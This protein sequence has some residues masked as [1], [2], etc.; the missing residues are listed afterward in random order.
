[1]FESE[2]GCPEATPP[3]F[4]QRI[5]DQYHTI[6]VRELTGSGS[7]IWDGLLP[8]IR[9]E[10]VKTVSQER[11]FQ[12]VVTSPPEQL[13]PGAVVLTGGVVGAQKLGRLDY[14]QVTPYIAVQFRLHD[15]SG[16]SVGR[17]TVVSC[18]RTGSTADQD[19]LEEM[20]REIGEDAADIVA[21]WSRSGR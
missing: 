7:A 15:D 21:S 16:G 1:V 4:S 3:E 14:F 18:G 8:I 10:V 11:A 20:A 2:T 6:I 17:F 5:T 12:S 13:P 9:T 19:D